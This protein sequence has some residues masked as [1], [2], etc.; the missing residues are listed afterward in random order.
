MIRL[1]IPNHSRP[2]NVATSLYLGSLEDILDRLRDLRANTVTLNQSN[3]VLA[4]LRRTEFISIAAIVL[5]EDLFV[6]FRRAVGAGKNREKK[7][8]DGWEQHV[9]QSPSGP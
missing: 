7:N 5:E 8:R 6:G 9:H 4:L 2:I 1:S 3:G